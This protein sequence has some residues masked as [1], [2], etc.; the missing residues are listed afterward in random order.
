MTFSGILEIAIGTSV[1]VLFWFCVGA[2]IG[3]F[4]DKKNKREGR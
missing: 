1:A 4:I 2:T 3:Y